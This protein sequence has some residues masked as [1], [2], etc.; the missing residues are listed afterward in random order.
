[1]LISKFLQYNSFILFYLVA[2]HLPCS[3]DAKIGIYL[4]ILLWALFG[5]G[6]VTF[7]FCL[8]ITK[9]LEDTSRDHLVQL[10]AEVSYLE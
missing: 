8:T 4:Y 3:R 9:L 10:P 6:G 7:F 1:M 5:Q 2:F